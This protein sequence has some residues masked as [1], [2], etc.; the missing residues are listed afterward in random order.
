MG[1]FRSV[2]CRELGRFVEVPEVVGSVVSLTPS[3]TAVLLDLGLGDLI[4]GLS[5]W[6]G[7]LRL[8]GY[9]VP[10]AP[11]L[12]SYDG[13]VVDRLVGVG[14]DLVLLAGG[15]Q[16]ARLVSVLEG[17]GIPY[18][19]TMLPRGIELLEFPV[20]LGYVL[21][22]VGRGVGLMRE[23][24]RLL[25]EGRESVVR[26]GVEGVRVAVVMEIGGPV[27]PGLASHV[28]Q[29]L[30]AV[31]FDVVNK[32]VV[33]A[34]YVWGGEADRVLGRLVEGCDVLLIQLATPDPTCGRVEGVLGGKPPVPTVAL[35]ILYLSDYS[36]AFLRRLPELAAAVARACGRG[37]SFC[38]CLA[39]KP[40]HRRGSGG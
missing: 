20:E 4:V 40:R 28:T 19:V 34:P 26:E 31:G 30:E 8:Y 25:W 22:V 15:Y 13:L 9:S 27:V 36:P 2:F 10:D 1:G 16:A 6:C 14:P 21:G 17:L 35:P 38:E 37:G 11:V 18:F 24:V 29:C 33:E 12:G 5:P 3:V 7:F 32:E 23:S 39:L